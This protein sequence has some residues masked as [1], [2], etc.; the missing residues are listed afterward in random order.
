MEYPG[1]LATDAAWLIGRAARPNSPIANRALASCNPSAIDEKDRI[2]Q[3]RNV[4]TETDG[5]SVLTPMIRLYRRGFGRR[6]GHADI[7]GTTAWGACKV[8]GSG[9]VRYSGREIDGF[10]TRMGHAVTRF[11]GPRLESLADLRGVATY[12][13]ELVVIGVGYFALARAGLAL[14]ALHSGGTPIWPATG[15]AVAAVL[16][17]GYRVWPAIFAAAWIAGASAAPDGTSDTG[18]IFTA[19]AIAVGNTL[20]VFAAGYFIEIWSGGLRTFDTP[21]GVAKSLSSSLALARCS[22]LPSG[23]AAC[24]L[25][26]TATG[27]AC[28]RPGSHGGCVMRSAS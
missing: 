26:A 27:Q 9:S 7:S 12:A 6:C 28:S 18:L 8:V 21:T 19:A 15:F 3:P 4:K 17:R 10:A 25:P 1:A 23:W 22:A 14:D 24:G 5:T 16:L 13:V 2:E 11:P 20:A